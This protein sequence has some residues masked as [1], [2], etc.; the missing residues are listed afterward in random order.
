MP[1]KLRRATEADA[2]HLLE[3]HRAAIAE[4]CS[5]SY[6]DELIQKWIAAKME[7]TYCEAIKRGIKYF[8]A[9]QDNMICG[10][11]SYKGSQIHDLF[12]T[13]T[14][15]KKGIGQQLLEYM[16]KDAQ[17]EQIS[18]FSLLSSLNAVGF[19]EKNGYQQVAEEVFLHPGGFEI[20]VVRLHKML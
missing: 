9:K 19:Y 13:P 4:I 7:E 16:E 8:V 11:S 17:E 5:K 6:P 20:P 3:V 14:Q 15:L 2:P 12:V 10:F 18:W 1:A